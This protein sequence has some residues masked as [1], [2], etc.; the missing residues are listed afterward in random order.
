M[1][2]VLLGL[3]GGYINVKQCEG[4]CIILMGMF[5]MIKG[6]LLGINLFVKI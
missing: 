4:L 2:C 6:F 1:R 5:V 3:L